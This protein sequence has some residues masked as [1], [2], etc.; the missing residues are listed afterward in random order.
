MDEDKCDLQIWMRPAGKTHAESSYYCCFYDCFIKTL[1]LSLLVF[2]FLTFW[3]PNFTR[4]Y[5]IS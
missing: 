2:Y 1:T 4:K 5:Y 3:Q